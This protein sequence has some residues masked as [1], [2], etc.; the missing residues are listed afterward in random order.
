MKLSGYLEKDLIFIGLKP[1]NKT[2]LIDHLLSLVEKK[3]PIG[4]RKKVLKDLMMRERQ[5]TTGIGCG[6]A[7]PHA[8]VDTLPKT[9]LA[10]ASIPGGV[11]FRSV[12]NVPVKVAFLL[13]SPPGL[14]GEHI[15]LL[16]RISRICSSPILVGKISSSSKEEEIMESIK[17]E[18][19]NRIG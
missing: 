10:M 17:S 19:E 12:D 3:Y 1:A 15:K 5:S 9:I 4:D 8:I 16:A 11:D 18:D 2:S 7:I 13:L 6:I 14:A